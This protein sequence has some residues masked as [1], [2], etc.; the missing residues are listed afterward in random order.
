MDDYKETMY[1]EQSREDQTKLQ[2][3]EG[4]SRQ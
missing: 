4:R 3:G 2:N 1:Y